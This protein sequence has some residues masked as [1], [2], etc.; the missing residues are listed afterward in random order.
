[1]RFAIIFCSQ[2]FGTDEKFYTFLCLSFLSIF[3]RLFII[4]FFFK[5]KLDQENFFFS[6]KNMLCLF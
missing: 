1:M 2:L 6:Q 4:N 5:K 3:F